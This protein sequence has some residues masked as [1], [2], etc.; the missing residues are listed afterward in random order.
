MVDLEIGFS[1]RECIRVPMRQSHQ[2]LIHKSK[3]KLRRSEIVLSGPRSNLCE[4]RCVHAEDEHRLAVH[5]EPSVTVDAN[6]RERLRVWHSCDVVP[7]DV[8]GG[9]VSCVVKKACGKERVHESKQY[10]NLGC[11]LGTRVML[12]KCVVHRKRGEFENI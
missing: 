5:N 6:R 8:N 9:R 7:V 12:I 4:L 2:C 1:L 10:G 11:V 3:I